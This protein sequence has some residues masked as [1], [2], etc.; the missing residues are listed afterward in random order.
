VGR[1][2]GTRLGAR[3]SGVVPSDIRAMTRAVEAVGGVNLGQG[4]CDLPTHPLVKAG[5]IEAIE[6]SRAAYSLYEGI[7]PLRAAIAKKLRDY[8]KVDADPASE[9]AVTVG[10]T[11]AF[12]LAILATVDPGDRVIL[13]EPFYSYH[14]NTTRLA[15]GEPLF[16]ATR[17]DGFAIDERALAAAAVRADVIVVCTPANP[18]GKVF[19][20]GELEMIARI[21]EEHDLLV[22][23]DEIYE[24]ILFDGREHVS[25]AS[26][27]DLRE[28]TIT[29]SGFSKTFSITG[30]RLGY[31]AGPADIIRSIGILSD[32]LYVCPPTP[33]QWGVLKGME[34]GPEYY[35]A[36]REDY[37]GLRAL[38]ADGLRAAG[39]RP[40]MPQ[41]AYY[42]LADYR[43][44]G[45][46]SAREAADTLLARTG[47]ASIP[48]T[49]FY[50]GTPGGGEAAG[51]HLLRFCFAKTREALEDA[52]GRMK[53]L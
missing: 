14:L 29:I 21:A 9:I 19:T 4:V 5:A 36:M 25:P 31:V 12:A 17:G 51:D 48:G 40:I 26:L 11:G 3:A 13:F 53:R 35:A 52:N 46:K 44:H 49:A 45:W 8:N 1:R 34:L 15:G 43:A 38:M 23:T 16:V 10:S 47:V 42:M 27:P 20:R 22:I 18:S 50:G 24:Y 39:F 6:A 7:A 30:W 37:A 41:G 2:R 32:L 28:R 33:L